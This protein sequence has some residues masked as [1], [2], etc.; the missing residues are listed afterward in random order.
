MLKEKQIKVMAY[1]GYKVNERPF[2]FIVNEERKK[3]KKILKRWYEQ[4][5][6]C[7]KV[8]ADDGLIYWLKWN[9]ILDSW[10]M[11]RKENTGD[12]L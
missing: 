9:R 12:P 2:C 8:F 5:H 1:S 3:I 7:Y 4:D 10:F 11:L 6:D